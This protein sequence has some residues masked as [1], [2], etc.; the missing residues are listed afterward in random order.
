MLSFLCLE[1]LDGNIKALGSRNSQKGGLVFLLCIY[2]FLQNQNYKYE[3]RFRALERA[4]KNGKSR[5]IVN[6]KSFPA[7]LPLGLKLTHAFVS[8]KDSYLVILATTEFHLFIANL[9]KI[10]FKSV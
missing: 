6:F 5:D 1:A 4:H 10:G 9:L 2:F 7:N 8:I 3:I